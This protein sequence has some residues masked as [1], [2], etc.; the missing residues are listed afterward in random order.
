MVVVVITV[1]KV[2]LKQFK[3]IGNGKKRNRS[4]QTMV[5]VIITVVMIQLKQFKII[6]NV[7]KK[8]NYK[9]KSYGTNIFVIAC[10]NCEDII[11]MKR[12]PQITNCK[13]CCVRKCG[14]KIRC[15]RRYPKLN[16]I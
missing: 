11:T 13:V 1:A 7:K 8:R 2:Q 10:D 12:R 16:N 4:R 3:I 15:R 5:V 6:E 9:K 14:V